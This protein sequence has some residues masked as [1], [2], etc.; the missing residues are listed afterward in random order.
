MAPPD[1]RMAIVGYTG[2]GKSHFAA[3]LYMHLVRVAAKRRMEVLIDVDSNEFDIA[4]CANSLRA[5][6]PLLPTP[7]DKIFEARLDLKF[8]GF[9]RKKRLAIPL[10]DVAGEALSATM[11]IMSESRGQIDYQSLM[12]EAQNQFNIPSE[13][14]THIHESVFRA[15]ALCFVFSLVREMREGSGDIEYR[16]FYQN[17]RAYKEKNDLPAVTFAGFIF[18]K[19]DEVRYELGRIFGN[20]PTAAQL[21]AH[22]V[23]TLNV[24]VSSSVSE[25]LQHFLSYTEWRVPPDDATG[26]EGEFKIV[27]DPIT[28]ERLPVYPEESYDHLVDWLHHLAR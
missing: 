27:V 11:K 12:A 26:K 16:R 14:L 8:P 22:F 2:S 3:L 23:P 28:S 10:M 20:E 7:P 17:L 4:G 5:G 1:K 13:E 19:A 6:V 24:E 9:F 21:A 18:T 25:P 15:D